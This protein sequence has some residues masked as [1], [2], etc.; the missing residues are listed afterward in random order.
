MNKR[1]KWKTKPTKE[2]RALQ[3]YVGDSK[4]IFPDSLEKIILTFLTKKE[5]V[6]YILKASSH[7]MRSHAIHPGVLRTSKHKELTD[8]QYN[9]VRGGNIR[10]SI[11]AESLLGAPRAFGLDAAKVTFATP[12][13][14][15]DEPCPNYHYTYSTFSYYGIADPEFMV[16]AMVDTSAVYLLTQGNLRACIAYLKRFGKEV[17]DADMFVM[18][19]ISAELIGM[20]V[21]QSIKESS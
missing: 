20:R 6:P 7:A 14:N 11:P 5:L 8:K 19:E 16:L 9:A 18:R 10:H 3:K 13:K 12:G 17:Q 4:I 15:A 1:I 2:V 21:E